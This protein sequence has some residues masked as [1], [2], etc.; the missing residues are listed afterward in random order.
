[1]NSEPPICDGK[2]PGER[3]D[4]HPEDLPTEERCLKRG[5]CWIKASVRL[6][7]GA[8]QCYFPSN[9]PGYKV[10]DSQLFEN[11]YSYF[12]NKKNSTFREKEILNL[13][14]DLFYETDERLRVKIYDRNNA[15]YEVPLDVDKNKG[16]LGDGSNRDYYVNVVDEP[17]AIKVYRKSTQ[18]LLFVAYAF[19]KLIMS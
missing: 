7:I 15:R 6:E 14:V 4:C 5:C 3:F 11:G 12:I 1:M 19:F 10:V 9:F 2:T 13:N 18:Q 17:F 16:K 8:P